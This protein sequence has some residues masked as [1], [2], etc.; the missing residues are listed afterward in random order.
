MNKINIASKWVLSLA[1][2]MF[3]TITLETEAQRRNR[4]N[5]EP[6]APAVDLSAAIYSDMQYR[7]IGPFRGG[8]SA[9]VTG[10]AGKPNFLD[11]RTI[12]IHRI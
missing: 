3:L 6:A 2:L 9:T 1:F 12:C 8:R 7:S 5:N 11:V 4:R 10:V